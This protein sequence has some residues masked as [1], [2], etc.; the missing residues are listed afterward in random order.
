MREDFL[1][2]IKDK[3][4]KRVGFRCSNPKCRKATSGPHSDSVNAINVGVAAHIAAAAPGG[5]RYDPAMTTEQRCSIDNGIWLCQVCAKLID[6]DEGRFTVQV[7]Q[8][9]RETAEHNARLEI[10]TSRHSAKPTDEIH[11]IRFAV[12]DWQMWRERGTLPDDPVVIVSCW[13]RGTVRY[14]FRFRLRNEL[15]EEDHIKRLRV[16]FHAGSAILCSDEY[17]IQPDE[18]ILPPRKWVTQEVSHGLYDESIFLKGTS[19]W[20]S[21]ETVGDNTLLRWHVAD[22]NPNTVPPPATE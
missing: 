7:L 6:S 1:Q 18:L 12:E 16:E 22:Y 2:P 9:W 19:V 4:A 14:A 3:L 5:P 20:V 17:A 21:A 8:D 11:S 13:G 15:A 10:S